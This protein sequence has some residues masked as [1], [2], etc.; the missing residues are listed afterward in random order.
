MGGGFTKSNKIKSF[1][2]L[3]KNSPLRTASP[4]MSSKKIKKKNTGKISH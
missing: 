1:I 3:G 2:K 4:L